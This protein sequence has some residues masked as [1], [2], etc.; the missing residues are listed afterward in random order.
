MDSLPKMPNPTAGI[1]KKGKWITSPSKSPNSDPEPSLETSNTSTTI[2][3]KLYPQ[4]W[5][6][7]YLQTVDHAASS[8]KTLELSCS[9]QDG[10]DPIPA[11]P[12]TQVGTQDNLDNR[13]NVTFKAQPLL[14]TNHKI[15]IAPSSD[16]ARAVEA[17]FALEEE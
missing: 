5:E 6:V 1:S 3:M 17:M 8:G 14:K 11:N 15:L 9:N 10:I 7:R 16:F 4:L 2:R 13:E 12:Q